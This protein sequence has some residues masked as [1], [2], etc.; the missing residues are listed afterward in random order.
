M[1]IALYSH[2]LSQPSRAVE[3]LLLELGYDYVWHEV[4][5]ARGATHT[6]EYVNWINAFAT[7]PVLHVE[8]S[9]GAT[10]KIS[11]SH[12]IMRYLCQTAA[13]AELG[14][15]WYPGG[16]DAQ[17]TARINQWLDWHL[18]NIRPH[19]LF[20]QVMN[21]HM[22]LPMLKREINAE[23]LRPRQAALSA[24]LV[25][26][27]RHLSSLDTQYPTLSGDDMPSIADLA[28]SSELYQ[29][30]AVGY[31][32]G[33]FPWVQAWLEAMTARDSF[34]QLCQTIDEQGEAIRRADGHYLDLQTGLMP[35]NQ[36]R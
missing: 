11:E 33:A 27:D 35:V 10:L 7:I 12:A 6:P 13:E 31:D 17:R 5:F 2:R 24:S 22:T 14:Q 18:G 34:C 8:G 29:A 26:L 21:L 16:Q 25:T 4:D 15:C 9:N 23:Q 20:H 28:I 36:G 19:D 1:P 32:F 30:R 3:V